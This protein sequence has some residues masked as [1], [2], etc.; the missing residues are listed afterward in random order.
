MTSLFQRL[1][2][3]CADEWCSYTHHAFVRGMGDGSLPEAAFRDYLVQDYLFLIQFARAY[4]LATYKA[5]SLSE[6]RAGLD[7]LKAILDVEMDLHVRLCAKWGL[8]TVDLETT[9]EKPQTIAYTRFVLDAG[10]AGDLL[11]LYAALA[12]CM[13]GYG[14]IGKALQ[15]HATPDNPYAEWIAEYASDGYQEIMAASIANL[16]ALAV[17]MLTENRYPR[18]KHLFSQATLLEADFWQMGLDAEQDEK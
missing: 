15:K 9:P 6:M 3:D 7:G 16:D 1:K 5:R 2:T 11:D 8:S 4:A 12:P 13:I 18:L 14:E 10:Q 17:D